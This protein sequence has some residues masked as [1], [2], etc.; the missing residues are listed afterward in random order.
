MAQAK[1]L[2]VE[3]SDVRGL[4]LSMI[5]GQIGDYSTVLSST[6]TD[7][8]NQ[9]KQG[10]FD[11]VMTNTEIKD[12]L[13]GIKLAQIVLLRE[14]AARPPV[15]VMVTLEK[16]LDLVRK[17]RQ[18]GVAD[19]LV[20]PYDPVNLLERVKKALD[21]REGL[22]EA[23]TRKAIV[24]T[25]KKIIDL[26]T[27]SQ[28]H[29]RIRNLL[30]SK[31]SSAADVARIMEIDQ[32]ITAKMLRLANSAIFGFNR[33][34]TSVKDAVALI[35]FDQ[36]ADLVT[37]VTTFEALGR[38]EESP[39]FNRLAFWEHSI[40]CGVIAKVI[41]EKLKIDPERAFVAGLLHD[42]G[43]VVLDGYFPEYFTEALQMAR[44]DGITIYEAEKEKLPIDHEVIGGHLA[45]QWNLPDAIT[46]VIASHH[47][48]KPQ[49]SM[50]MRLTCLTHLADAQCR[51]LGVGSAGDNIK[52]PPDS[53]ILQ[54][55]SV[56]EKDLEAWR[57]EIE[58]NIKHAQALLELVD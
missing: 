7:A 14:V 34:I 1:V 3:S 55:L 39:H 15:I 17:C 49:K 12:P 51:L 50:Y 57:P 22:S 27:I 8:V 40:G 16:N 58:K 32:S 30:A 4:A 26:P 52:R 53:R 21:Q 19:Y 29:D 23:Q 5:L 45:R 46:D 43:K 47:T 35:G 11:L 13:D 48:L 38:V 33:H 10:S 41:G 28:V 9:I 36:V 37:A 25:L 18:L 42:I 31:K 2:I 56:K 54:R 6:V 44:N 24:A 20:Y